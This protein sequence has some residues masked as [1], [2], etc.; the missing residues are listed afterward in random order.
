MSPLLRVLAAVIASVAFVAS[1][2]A[3][4]RV[5]LGPPA[6]EQAE[7]SASEP[8]PSPVPEA[9]RPTGGLDPAAALELLSS[10]DAAE[11]AGAVEV[12]EAVTTAAR[13]PW[14]SLSVSAW[15][16][17]S[18][19]PV[20]VAD[21]ALDLASHRVDADV[22]IA[23]TPAEA[24]TVLRLLPASPVTGTD[25][26]TVEASIDGEQVPAEVDRKGNRLL[27]DTPTDRA[28]VLRLRVGYAVPD[29]A[30]LAGDGG[31]ASAGLLAWDPHVTTLGHWLPVL[32]LPGER[33]A[34]VPWGDVGGFPAATWSVVVRHD[35]HL[36]TGATDVECP[37][38][39]A[40]DDERCTWAR[41]LHLR[42]VSAVAFP[43]APTTLGVEA[44]GIGVRSHV[45]IP[46]IT[47]AQGRQLVEE[48]AGAVA[49]FTDRLG[50]LA[51]HEVDVVAA[52]LGDRVAG[53]EFPGLLLLD[54]AMLGRLEGG[55]GT[56][57][58]AHEVAHQWFHA[59]VGNGSLQDPVVDESIAQ[60][61]TFVFW[62]EAF[63]E[64]AA[65]RLADALFRSSYRDAVD[66]GLAPEPPAQPLEEFDGAD[67]YGSLV[68]GRAAL[69]WV[70]AEDAIGR[71]GVLEFLHSLVETHGLDEVTDDDVLQAARRFDVDLGA[72]LERYWVTPE[73]LS[74]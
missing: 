17:D 42:D 27:I 73:H 20:Y 10:P 53:M 18:D 43:T 29:R 35:G 63:G 25:A 8:S 21:V 30:D 58:A 23:F 54:T 47:A 60:Y 36:V 71:A 38:R 1:S 69:G 65:D 5:R 11:A 41:G 32:T 31:P 51:W 4:S 52:P 22:A 9:R 16:L 49:V 34:P 19:A 61:L 56:A 48:A 12:R 46:G 67:A 50:P 13:G 64:P 68:Y 57:V 15:P 44:A 40:A 55:I 26:P 66:A 28:V 37:D 72:V 70:V 33:G 6:G 7:A 59:L 24:T 39:L 74:P 14:R 45:G 62:A 3:L 2:V